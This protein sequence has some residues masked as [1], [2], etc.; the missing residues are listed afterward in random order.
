MSYE[1]GENPNLI[2]NDMERLFKYCRNATT[3][4]RHHFL[5]WTEPEHID[6]MEKIGITEDFTLEYAD[7]AGFR[8][9]TCRPYHFINPKT[10]RVSNV[11]EHP[12]QIMECSLDR[13]QYMNLD[14]ERA[15]KICL[16]L[17]DAT[18]DFAGELVLL[19]H[20]PI[21]SDANYYGRLY[22][23]L[24]DYIENLE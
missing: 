11:I 5:R 3:K 15:L 10:K 24:L 16:K 9:G 19:F 6:D 17:I 4:S 8:V 20:N 7:S 13:P 18:Y 22:L 21:F 23:A 14:Y 2:K 12:M 1:A